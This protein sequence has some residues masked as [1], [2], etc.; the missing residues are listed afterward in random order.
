MN[1][2]LVMGIV[3]MLGGCNQDEVEGIYHEDDGEGTRVTMILES[4]KVRLWQGDTDLPPLTGHYRQE[5][6][7]VILSLAGRVLT[8]SLEG[9]C[10][11]PIDDPSQA[12][13]KS[14]Y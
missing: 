1:V 13:C 8:L 4:G 5:A 3:L 7:R 2:R 9:N 10:L 14:R 11:Y 12:I 6:G